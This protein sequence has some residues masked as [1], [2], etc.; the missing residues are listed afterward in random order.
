MKPKHAR[1]ATKADETPEFVELWEKI[2]PSVKS[3][4]DARAL[5]RDGFF[6][7]VWW[8]NAE[9][10]DIV[11]AAKAYVRGAK[12][13]DCRLLLSNWLD[14]GFYEDMAEAERAY[15]QRAL[16]RQHQKTNVVSM[17][18]VLPKN[19]FLNRAGG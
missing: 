5:A 3:Q 1:P 19:H 6:R 11:D 7:H 4:Y 13:G 8:L 9:P 14:R 2:W 15:Q 12:A 17:N 10:R 16:D 18:V